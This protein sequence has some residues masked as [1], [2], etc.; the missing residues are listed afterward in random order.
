M[1]AFGKL[2][3]TGSTQIPAPLP[4]SAALP[5]LCPAQLLPLSLSARLSPTPQPLS[6]PIRPVTSARFTTHLLR[7]HCRTHLPVYLRPLATHALR[8]RCWPTPIPQPR[9]HHLPSARPVSPPRSP[10]HHLC[11]AHSSTPPPIRLSLAYPAAPPDSPSHPTPPL[12][13]LTTRPPHRCLAFA[14]VRLLTHSAVSDRPTPPPCPLI[15]RPPTASVRPTLIHSA[16]PRPTFPRLLRHLRPARLSSSPPLCPSPVVAHYLF[17]AHPPFT[18]AAP[19]S[20]SPTSLP[21]R[22]AHTPFIAPR[23]SLAHST[24]SCRSSSPPA[25]LACLAHSHC[26]CS[27]TTRPVPSPI[28]LVGRLLGLLRPADSSPSEVALFT[29]VLLTT[30]VGSP[31][32]QPPLLDRS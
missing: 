24:V 16:R 2:P 31:R 32:W 28:C 23:L 6:N 29:V 14:P 4:S 9:V 1:A 11:L 26:L 27:P 7:S 25:R 21:V 12:W 30:H 5:Y 15:A 20:L 22:S 13:F 18:P 3:L 8:S 19:S 10:T 17:P